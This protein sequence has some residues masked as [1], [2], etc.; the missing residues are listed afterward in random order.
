MGVMDD[1]LKLSRDNTPILELPETLRNDIIP[2]HYI[3]LIKIISEASEEDLSRFVTAFK[4]EASK[5]GV[6]L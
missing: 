4:R 5:L 1:Y 3:Q 2:D 6:V